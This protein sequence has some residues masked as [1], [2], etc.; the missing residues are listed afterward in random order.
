VNALFAAAIL[1]VPWSYVGFMGDPQEPQTR[2]ATAPSRPTQ[3]A[4]METIPDAGIKPPAHLKVR[5]AAKLDAVS[6]S[7]TAPSSRPAPTSMPASPPIL[8]R[9]ADSN[10]KVW[11][12]EDPVWL[13]RWVE[14]RNASLLA[15][16]P[17]VRFETPMRF[18]APVI[19]FA[20]SCTSG[21][22]FRSP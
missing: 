9:L 12:H 3:A 2:L 5:P 10:G 21:R 19:P 20:P 14:S 1:A 8:Y 16:P 7:S 13:R 18:E 17:A 6:R 4:S 11:E 15:T 22:C